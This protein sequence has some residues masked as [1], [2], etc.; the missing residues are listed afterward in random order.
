MSTL[1]STNKMKYFF[2]H[3]RQAINPPEDT[4]GSH[5]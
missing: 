4:Y 5:T 1:N 2:L 3:E